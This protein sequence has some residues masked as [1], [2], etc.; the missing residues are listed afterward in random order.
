MFEFVDNMY[1]KNKTQDHYCSPEFKVFRKKFSLWS[2]QSEFGRTLRFPCE[3]EVVR[4]IELYM[5][6]HITKQINLDAI[7]LPD[8]VSEQYY[9]DSKQQLLCLLNFNV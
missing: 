6:L 8:W 1:I 4:E 5:K 9:P 7:A 2:W 3:N